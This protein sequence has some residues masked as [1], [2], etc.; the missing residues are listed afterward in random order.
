MVVNMLMLVFL[1]VTLCGL[2]GK[3]SMFQRN[4]LLPSLMMEAVCSPKRW[5]LPTG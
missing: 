3:I 2:V 5:Y 1:I 4:I